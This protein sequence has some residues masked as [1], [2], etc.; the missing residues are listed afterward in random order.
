MS[1]REQAL[2]EA[3]LRAAIEKVHNAAS[4]GVY[5]VRLGDAADAGWG[6]TGCANCFGPVFVCIRE[7]G[8]D[9]VSHDIRCNNLRYVTQPTLPADDAARA[10][11]GREG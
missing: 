9:G 1:E 3:T 11:D 8:C 7:S 2:T 4:L 10:A 6:W 5:D